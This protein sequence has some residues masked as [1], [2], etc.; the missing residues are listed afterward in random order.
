MSLNSPKDLIARLR[1]GKT[2]RKQ[3]VESHLGKTMAT[4]IRATRDQRGWTQGRLAEEVGMNQNAISRL[5]SPS[6]AKPTLTTLKR[7]A[8]AFDVALVVRFVPFSEL[9]PW[10]SGTPHTNP[11]LTTQ[12]LMV[13]S[14]EMEYETEQSEPVSLSAKE[15]MHLGVLPV[16]DVLKDS[17]NISRGSSIVAIEKPVARHQQEGNIR[18]G[19]LEAGN[20]AAP[21]WTTSARAAM[22]ERAQDA[23]A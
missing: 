23:R 21:L 20:Q 1:R 6:Y 10:V 13:P 7:L 4:Q 12:A 14:F 8:A 17:G 18:S 16:E 15:S 19:L 9:V 5:E 11:G 2:A 22:A 3:F